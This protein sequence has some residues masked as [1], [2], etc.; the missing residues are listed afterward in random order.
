MI[1][2]N[3]KALSSIFKKTKVSKKE[4]ATKKTKKSANTAVNSVKPC[5]VNMKRS[6]TIPK[7]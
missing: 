1:I 2:K 5:A 7:L 6:N 4:V 3:A